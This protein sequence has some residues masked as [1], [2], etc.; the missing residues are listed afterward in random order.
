MGNSPKKSKKSPSPWKAPVYG[1][2]VFVL[3]FI[4]AA[5]AAY[6]VYNIFFGSPVDLFIS[7]LPGTHDKIAAISEWGGIAI[8]FPIA[9]A[10]AIATVFLAIHGISIS[11]NA[12]D[13]AKNANDI[14]ELE[15]IQYLEDKIDKVMELHHAIWASCINAYW[16]AHDPDVILLTEMAVYGNK[17][18]EQQLDRINKFHKRMIEAV[19][20]I[21]NALDAMGH[22]RVGS[23]FFSCKARESDSFSKL[24]KFSY[25]TIQYCTAHPKYNKLYLENYHSIKEANTFPGDLSEDMRTE[26]QKLKD[27]IDA[28]EK[29]QNGDYGYQ[30][31]YE[32]QD[33]L[34]YKTDKKWYEYHHWNKILAP[35]LHKKTIDN[36]Q[37]H[38]GRPLVE[39]IPSSY[40][41][42]AMQIKKRLRSLKDADP[43]FFFPFPYNKNTNTD[44]E[45]DLSATYWLSYYLGFDVYCVGT[46]DA[47][48]YLFDEFKQQYIHENSP[49]KIS[50]LYN[51]PDLEYSVPVDIL[52]IINTGL[53]LLDGILTVYPTE[54]EI[55]EKLRICYPGIENYI[56]KISI[57]KI[58]YETPQGLKCCL[59]KSRRRYPTISRYFFESETNMRHNREMPLLYLWRDFVAFEV[60]IR[61]DAAHKD[62]NLR[63]AY[64]NARENFQKECDTKATPSMLPLNELTDYYRYKDWNRHNRKSFFNKNNWDVHVLS[65]ADPRRE[66]EITFSQGHEVK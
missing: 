58:H 40:I 9:I 27:K 61:A 29:V 39:N 16:V 55:R 65:P 43:E 18:K 25:K 48:V 7:K 64:D 19:E 31:E 35:Y 10:G 66:G 21:A 5:A 15:R 51:S 6:I 53:I 62:K 46:R 23:E 63:K 26:L 28:W 11:R 56:E 47:G 60:D 4:S 45:N 22:N 24:T 38:E 1:L 49:L 3:V 17:D 50:D 13:I 52:Q 44:T 33:Y 32:I 12:N 8:G 30:E 20:G 59:S 42:Y 2:V 36:L 34:S 14:A 41:E 37:M 57:G 54:Y